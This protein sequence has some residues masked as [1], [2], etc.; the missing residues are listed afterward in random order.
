MKYITLFL[1]IITSLLCINT[2]AQKIFYKNGNLEFNVTYNDKGQK[3]GLFEHYYESGQLKVKKNYNDK[4][5]EE[6]GVYIEYHENGEIEIKGNYENGKQIGEWKYYYEN[7]NIKSKCTY[8]NDHEVGFEYY[9]FENGNIYSIDEYDVNGNNTGVSKKYNENGILMKM[10]KYLENNRT[11]VQTYY[12]NGKKEGSGEREGISKVGLWKEY[13][14]NGNIKE[15][16]TYDDKGYR[17]GSWKSYHENGM[18]YQIGQYSN[19]MKI[20]YWEHYHD[21]G[22]IWHCGD[23]NNLGKKTGEWFVYFETGNIQSEYQF[24]EKK[25]KYINYYESGIIKIKGNYID[26]N[27]MIWFK[28]FRMYGDQEGLWEY[29]YENGQL[30]KTGNYSIVRK[31]IDAGHGF[32]RVDNTA[33][34]N[35]IWKFYYNNG[36]LNAVIEY[37]NGKIWNVLNLYDIKGNSLDI[38]TIKNGNGTIKSYDEN[39]K[40]IE[41]TNFIK[42][43]SK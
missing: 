15:I 17:T 12:E 25:T 28:G 23:F 2:Q 19:N 21:N 24:N 7:G 37:K 20:G 39:G 29:Y 5:N 33:Y 26:T 31:E 13:H 27:S 16:G 38:G 22:E 4:G 32:I 40:L 10:E 18:P 42:G 43:E 6:H 34:K 9:Y 35:E 11:F 1:L 36:Q 3:I 14:E 8:K 30:A 41:K